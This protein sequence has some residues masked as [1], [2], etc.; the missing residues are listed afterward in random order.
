M[1][2][3]IGDSLNMSDDVSQTKESHSAARVVC[4]RTDE[5]RGEKVVCIRGLCGLLFQG[6]RS[7]S[8]DVESSASE[9]PPQCQAM[10]RFCLTRWLGAAK[11]VCPCRSF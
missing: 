6:S 1:V 3:Y 9:S 7:G 8:I 5:G 10:R 2:V 11:R 4:L